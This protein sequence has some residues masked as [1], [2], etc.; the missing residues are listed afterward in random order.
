MA[1]VPYKQR[2]KCLQSTKEPFNI[3]QKH[4]EDTTHHGIFK[5]NGKKNI[6]MK[7]Q[8]SLLDFKIEKH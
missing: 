5:V 2:M 3:K 6:K 4:D 1:T 7:H 8:D